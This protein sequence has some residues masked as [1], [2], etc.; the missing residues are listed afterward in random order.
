MGEQNEALLCKRP[1]T[2]LAIP[3]FFAVKV[4]SI[5]NN[6]FQKHPIYVLTEVVP[7]QSETSSSV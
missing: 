4:V 1:D 6:I 2:E 5:F 7:M 3:M